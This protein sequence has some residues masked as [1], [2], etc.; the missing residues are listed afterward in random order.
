[1]TLTA[2]NLKKR[3]IDMGICPMTHPIVQ[4]CGLCRWL[5]YSVSNVDFSDPELGGVRSTQER[6]A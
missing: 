6:A 2:F 3:T 1:M 4:L 5:F